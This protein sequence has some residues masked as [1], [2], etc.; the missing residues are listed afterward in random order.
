MPPDQRGIQMIYQLGQ[1]R[2]ESPIVLAPSFISGSS[3]SNCQENIVSIQYQSVFPDPLG[4]NPVL[5]PN[6]NYCLCDGGYFGGSTARRPLARLHVQKYSFA[7]AFM[8]S[9]IGMWRS[10]H[11]AAPIRGQKENTRSLPEAVCLPSM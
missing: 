7:M 9:S 2:R 10:K 4:A 6:S 1:C 11:A 3:R 8:Q 5:L